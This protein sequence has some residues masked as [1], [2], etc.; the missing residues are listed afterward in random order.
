[1]TS[2]DMT[3]IPSHVYV[4]TDTAVHRILPAKTL[5]EWRLISSMNDWRNKNPQSRDPND[6]IIQE[7]L[8]YLNFI[9][10]LQTILYQKGLELDEIGRWKL[11][12]DYQRTS[13]FCVALHVIVGIFDA[14]QVK[15]ANYDVTNE[16]I[17]GFYK[18]VPKFNLLLEEYESETVNR[19]LSHSFSLLSSMIQLMTSN[20]TDTILSSW[21]SDSFS[22]LKLYIHNK[23]RL[24]FN[25][26][27]DSNDKILKLAIITFCLSFLGL[28][29]AVACSLG[30]G[31]LLR[32]ESRLAVLLADW[33]SH[34]ESKVDEQKEST[35]TVLQQVKLSELR[36]IFR[37]FQ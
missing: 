32:E 2:L 23:R 5:I 16:T 17:E 12:Y 27:T 19:S 35:H 33:F 29:V 9:S 8:F 11:Y 4:Q 24:Q 22:H 34:L 15:N 13:F 18:I 7:S 3:S 14:L 26:L 30:F 20:N 31:Y 25:E 6:V 10:D 37:S 28:C 36:L 21:T 1:M